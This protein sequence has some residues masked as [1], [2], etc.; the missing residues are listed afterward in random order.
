MYTIK[1]VNFNYGPDITFQSEEEAKQF[2]I[3]KHF[4]FVIYYNDN[5]VGTW[6]MFG[7]YQPYCYHMQ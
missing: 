2:G 3:S 5:I 1:Y 4:E 7:G 6:S